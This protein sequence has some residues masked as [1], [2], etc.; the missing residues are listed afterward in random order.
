MPIT[1]IMFIRSTT[2]EM[3]LGAE[4]S[5]E[6]VSCCFVAIAVS[7]GAAISRHPWQGN[8]SPA[9]FA[10]PSSTPPDYPNLSE[11]FPYAGHPS[12]SFLIALCP[13]PQLPAK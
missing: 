9:S 4:T 2:G 12:A 13:I 10:P 5:Y 1:L 6:E 8:P 3:E 11:N 7:L